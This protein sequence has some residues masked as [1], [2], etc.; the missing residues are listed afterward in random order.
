VTSRVSAS[1]H[2]WGLA[3]YVIRLP[4]LH[5]DRLLFTHDMEN[6]GL[7]AVT[8]WRADHLRVE[9]KSVQRW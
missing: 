9:R 2:W 4:I 7:G 3:T 6:A 1:S 5:Q 8:G